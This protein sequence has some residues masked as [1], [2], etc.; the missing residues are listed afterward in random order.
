MDTV[1]KN[2]KKGKNVDMQ[3]AVKSNEKVRDMVLHT[4]PVA[5]LEQELETKLKNSE[6]KWHGLNKEQAKVRLD[7]YGENALTEK[8][9]LPWYCVFAQ[10]LTGFFSL[11]LWFGSLLCFIG[12]ALMPSDPANLYLGLVLAGVV[13]LTGCFSYYQTSK[14]A[15]LMAQFKNFIPPKAVAVRNGEVSEID[16]KTLVPGDIIKVKGGD[17]VPADIR[18]LQSHEMKVSNASLTGESEDLLRL[19]DVSMK[20]PLESP[21]LAFFGTQCT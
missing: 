5:Q 20:N 18:I 13:F 10:E 8:K 6:G 1:L 2:K 17:N 15:S 19:A 7:K 11:L 9:G 12:Y 4:I 3:E 21:N 16:A 14:S